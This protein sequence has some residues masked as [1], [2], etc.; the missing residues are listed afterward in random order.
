VYPKNGLVVV[1]LQLAR[2]D[3]VRLLAGVLAPAAADAG[4]QVDEHAKRVRRGAALLPAGVMRGVAGERS[5]SR[6]SD[7]TGAEL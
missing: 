6:G 7:A 5:R 2:L 3:A 4:A 1:R